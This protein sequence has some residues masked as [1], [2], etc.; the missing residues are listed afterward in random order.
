ML[1]NNGWWSVL[2]IGGTP[3][4][5]DSGSG[6]AITVGSGDVELAADGGGWWRLVLNQLNLTVS[7]TIW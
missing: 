3:I 2:P 4:I 1:N 5:S 6:E 7:G